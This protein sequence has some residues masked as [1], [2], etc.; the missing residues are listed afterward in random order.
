LKTSREFLT[1]NNYDNL[2]TLKQLLVK[3]SLEIK[4]MYFCRV[5]LELEMIIELK[6]YKVFFVEL[7]KYNKYNFY[8]LL[9]HNDE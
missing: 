1:A 3:W 2:E 7:Y 6:K 4:K 5:Y 9:I 8:S